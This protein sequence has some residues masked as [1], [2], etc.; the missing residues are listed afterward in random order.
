MDER[1][2]EGKSVIRLDFCFRNRDKV[3]MISSERD[4]EVDGVQAYDENTA[5]IKSGYTGNKV[6]PRVLSFCA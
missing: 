6:M 5:L 1:L 3:G 4:R 2:K